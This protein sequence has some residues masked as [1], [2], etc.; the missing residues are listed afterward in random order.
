MPARLALVAV[1]LA[2][3][4][5]LL[6]S[7]A[8][9]S[10]I[11]T[12]RPAQVL[13]AIERQPVNSVTT[14]FSVSATT[15]QRGISCTVRGYPSVTV[16]GG[17]HGSVMVATKP[18]LVGTGGPGRVV[19]LS[20]STRRTGGFYA[21]STH[22]CEGRTGAVSARV[23]FGLPNGGGTGGAATVTVCKTESAALVV[24]PFSG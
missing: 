13:F 22:P 11:G 14:A 9:T 3:A 1:S 23:R 12:C 17:A 19:I 18:H 10:R 2:A 4:L 24:G 20:S 21:V 16:P 5:L 7:S 15:R 8:A 6:G